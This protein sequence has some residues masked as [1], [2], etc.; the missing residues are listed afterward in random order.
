MAFRDFKDLHRRAASDKILTDK[1][2][3]IGKNPKMVGVKEN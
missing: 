2:F 3:S 1:A